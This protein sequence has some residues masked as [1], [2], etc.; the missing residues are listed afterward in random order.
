MDTKRLNDKIMGAM[1]G[2]AIGDALG[3][4]T[5]FMNRD[6]VKA[7][8]PDGLTRFDQMI[9]DAHRSIWG[10]GNWS[11]DTYFLIMLSALIM[12][13]D[14]FDPLAFAAGMYEWYSNGRYD[15]PSQLRLVLRE[16]KYPEDPYGTVVKVWN[17]IGNYCESSSV[18]GVSALCGMYTRQAEKD[19][20]DL[21]ATLQAGPRSLG[22]SHIIAA[23]VSELL[24]KDR[25]MT[26]EEIVEIANRYSPDIEPFIHYAAE[27]RMDLAQVDDWDTLWW[28]RKA[29]CCALWALWNADSFEHGVDYVI[30]LGGDADTNGALAAFLLGLKFGRSSLPAHLAEGLNKLE[31]IDAIGARWGEYLINDREK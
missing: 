4:G 5:E 20:H 31:E 2:Y 24:W 23:V 16:E 22:C 8:Y 15:I 28:V 3:L 7:N 12:R 30:N 26:P 11:H 21:C 19:S 6:E 29:T 9:Q 18:L 17:K 14:R 13:D 10:K 27:D 1:T 25:I